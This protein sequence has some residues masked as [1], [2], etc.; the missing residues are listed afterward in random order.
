MHTF[1]LSVPSME[2]SL[3]G[4]QGDFGTVLEIARAH[5]RQ[6]EAEVLVAM[7]GARVGE[8]N[9]WRIQPDGRMSVEGVQWLR[10]I[11]CGD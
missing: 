2:F 8:P 6:F 7:E 5:A 4:E 1:Y 3:P 9:R 11:G 10:C